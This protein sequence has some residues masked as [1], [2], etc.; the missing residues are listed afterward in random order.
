MALPPWPC[1]L[2]VIPWAYAPLAASA[3]TATS[4]H[5]RSEVLFDM[6]NSLLSVRLRP[7]IDPPPTPASGTFSPAQ[8]A[9]RL[10]AKQPSLLQHKRTRG[11]TR[12]CGRALFYSFEHRPADLRPCSN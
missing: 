9:T 5:T 2:P 12:T 10:C 7:T 4:A 1:L 8:P 11:E 3:N 6:M